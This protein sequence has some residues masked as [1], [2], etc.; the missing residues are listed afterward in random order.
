MTEFL[1]NLQ[2]NNDI[3]VLTHITVFE[4]YWVLKSVYNT[5]KQTIIDRLTHLFTIPKLEIEHKLLI[6]ETLEIFSNT[7]VGLEDSYHISWS[8]TNN[9]GDIATF[10]KKLLKTWTKYKTGAKPLDT[11]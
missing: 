10:D 4:V 8:K 2:S 9:I 3:G 6:M 7:N 11:A 5:S 1:K